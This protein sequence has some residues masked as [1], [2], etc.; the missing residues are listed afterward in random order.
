MQDD[1][2]RTHRAVCRSFVDEAMF[3]RAFGTSRADVGATRNYLRL[4]LLARP[5]LSLYFDREFYLAT[6]PDVRDAGVDPLV[7]FIENGCAALRPP[8]PLIDL[9]LIVAD[10]PTMLG[11][12]PSL[13]ALVDLLDY[14][15][16]R[17]SAYFDIDFYRSALG[18]AA[19]S[20][21]LLRH[22]L[23]HGLAARQRPNDLLDPEYYYGA[24][25][26]VP[27]D[28]YG[29]LRHFV[30][31]GDIEGRRCGPAFDGAFY[32]KRYPDVAK[33]DVPPLCHYLLYGRTEGR[34]A[35]AE[36]QE[37]VRR[38]TGATAQVDAGAPVPI[39]AES[40]MAP[41]EGIGRRIAA[42]RQARK[43]A[44]LAAA[45]RSRTSRSAKRAR[46]AALRF[47]PR[48]MPRV[49]IIVPMFN[50]VAYT[51]A[52]LRSI[53]AAPPKS[54]CEVIVADDCSTDPDAAQLGRIPGLI[55]LR[56][57][58]NDGFLRTCNAAFRR[59]RGVYVLFLNND[60]EL[61]PDAID[62]LVA[63]L[64]GDP[65]IAAA[66]P[67]LIYPD[68]LL[69]EA[70]C[71]VK[72][73]GES[74]MVGLFDDPADPAYG[75]DRDVPYC[76]GAA[77]LVR[78]EM[79]DGDP[80]DEAF[81]PAYCEDVDLCLR[82]QAGG[83]RVRFVH[84]AVVVHHL[85]VSN[86]RQSVARKLRGIARNQHKLVERWGERLCEMDRVRPIA[87]YLPQ[88]H[89]TVEND[90]WWGAGFTEWTNVAKARPSY[91]G[92]Y[93]P[94]LPADLGF[95]DLRNPQVLRQQA[96]LAA[97][98]GIEGFSI[99]YYNFGGRRVLSRPLELLRENPEIPFHFCLCWANENW[100]KHWDGGTREILLEQ[101]YDED[102][103]RAILDDVTA[104]AA[105][106]RA[107]RL[108]GK[109][110]FLVYR[111]LQI[112]EPKRFATQCRGAFAAA[113]F[114]GVHLIYV[115]SMEAADRGI[116]PADLGFDAAVEF[117]PHKRA[118]P[119]NGATDILKNGWSGYRYDYAETAASFV[120]RP[121][122]PYIRYPA[123]FASW[124]NTAR[125]P[126]LGTSF[127]NV[128]PAAF[129]AF[130]E[131]K[132]E[133]VRS[134]HMGESRLLF[135]N[136]WNEWAEGAHLEPDM[137]YGH[138]WLEGLRDALDAARFA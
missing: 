73:N 62:R 37:F 44:A 118:V 93:Q 5:S 120:T 92:H 6:N 35:L 78:R 45:G 135:I 67:K 7:H 59:S 48:K 13:E 39:D 108:D 49:S 127:D 83:H 111:P 63:A 105:D 91:A 65:G 136:A 19:P 9:R 55:Y 104:Y 110:I 46:T 47:P 25:P 126:L 74:G 94:H 98:Y 122:V 20:D 36:R 57:D 79:I 132:I 99:Y 76:S 23:A 113:G 53:A 84:D 116:E 134:F 82:L 41:Y 11:S 43:D 8:H 119:A 131:A 117:P 138:A 129:R 103:I 101:H 86:N 27:R 114:D 87:F 60:T 71:Y 17:S 61:R 70:G 96:A 107:L 81:K 95:Y 30:I 64:D 29:A 16:A 106:P 133:E 34:Q 26:D 51:L 50:E 58:S 75:R 10:E 2:M 121:G 128:S 85:S 115:E 52:C 80:F 66:G 77:L 15:L 3:R 40:T 68:G 1:L 102:T 109:P 38:S 28:P 137:A 100:T 130:A 32:R 123:I 14:D 56:Q 72:P 124:D 24:Y 4:P 97:R 31:L 112:P 125:Q 12:P 89:P 42:A 22:F 90:L 18:D 88:F 33:S 21:G 54:A 69:Q